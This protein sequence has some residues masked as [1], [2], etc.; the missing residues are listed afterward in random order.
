MSQKEKTRQLCVPVWILTDCVIQIWVTKEV[1]APSSNG[2]VGW[3]P[4]S[5]HPAFLE[6]LFSKGTAETKQPPLPCPK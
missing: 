5:P 2:C 1:K 3:A 6:H 4:E